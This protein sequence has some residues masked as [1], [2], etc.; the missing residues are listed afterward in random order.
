MQRQY[1]G[2]ELWVVVGV[3]IN[4]NSTPGGRRRTLY[5]VSGCQWPRLGVL[6]A[7]WRIELDLNSPKTAT[8]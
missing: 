2:A 6:T 1:A 5:E 8:I 7:P 4:V 3:G